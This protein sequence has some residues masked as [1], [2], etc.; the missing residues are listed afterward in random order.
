MVQEYV[1]SSLEPIEA[2]FV[3]PVTPGA[4]VCGF[5]AFIN[6]K[7][8]V[9]RVKEKQAAHREYKAAISQGKGA[10]LMDE[11]KESPDV[12]TVSVGNL[13]PR[14]KVLV[15][16]TYVAELAVDAVDDSVVFTLP[17]ALL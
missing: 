10:Y 6:G 12:L 1:N 11:S 13:P 4:A 17:S 8:I 14:C 9:G 16:I 2:R 7:H 5:E 3:F 15:K